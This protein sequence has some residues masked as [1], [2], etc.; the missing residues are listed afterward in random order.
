MTS[1][2]KCGYRSR[3]RNSELTRKALFCLK[4]SPSRSFMLSFRRYWLSV[5]RT[6]ANQSPICLE[7]ILWFCSYLKLINTPKRKECKSFNISSI[8][9]ILKSIKETYKRTAP[10]SSWHQTK[11]SSW[12]WFAMR[13]LISATITKTIG[14]TFSTLYINKCKMI[15]KAIQKRHFSTKYHECSTFQK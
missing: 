6:M 8:I 2:M 14:Y 7:L 11:N 15:F 13:F 10:I 1:S 3:L 4:K 9:R 12:I 5:S